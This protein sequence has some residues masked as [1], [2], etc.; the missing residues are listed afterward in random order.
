MT[1]FRVCHSV[2]KPG[3]RFA[4]ARPS[5]RLLSDSNIFGEKTCKSF[6]QFQRLGRLA[7]H[8]INVRRDFPFAGESFAPACQQN[9]GRCRRFCLHC[10]G[11]GTAI[12]VRH[13]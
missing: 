8:T 3:N 12:Y 13:S 9:H 4:V 11:D 2:V 5:T 7:E 10:G 1:R 6:A